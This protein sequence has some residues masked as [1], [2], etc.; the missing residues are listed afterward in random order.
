MDGRAGAM[1]SIDGEVKFEIRNLFVCSMCRE[2]SQR[3]SDV[4]CD[5]RC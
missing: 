5:A 4:T 2:R 3:T 1:I